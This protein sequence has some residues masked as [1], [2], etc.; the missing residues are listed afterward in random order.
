MAALAG[1]AVLA[2][3]SNPQA[4]ELL[5]ADAPGPDSTADITVW[6][7]EPGD[8]LDDANQVIDNAYGPLAIDTVTPDGQTWTNGLGRT[9][10]GGNLLA[11]NLAEEAVVSA[12]TPGE[13]ADELARSS[14][15]RTTVLRRG[16]YVQTAEGCVLATSATDVD[17][18]GSGSCAISQDE[19]WVASWS[20]TGEGLTIRD[21]R[22]DSTETVEG[23]A[24]ARAAVLS[25]DA[26]VLAVVVGESGFEAVL[27]DAT[28][29]SEIARSEPYPAL[30]V[31]SPDPEAEGF[32]LSAGAEDGNTLL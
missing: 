17:D 3:C 20:A 31:A 28:D 5:V 18:V 15:A 19:R 13:V 27:L 30:E 12:G 22:N 23:L 6:S 2:G 29:G 9:W 32:V 7:V 26:R 4:G 21:L 14:S 1:A 10:Q 25:K 24:V 11:Y 16:T 8:E